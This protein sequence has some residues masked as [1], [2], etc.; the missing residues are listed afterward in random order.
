[1]TEDLDHDIADCGLRAGDHVITP[2]GLG[3]VC[4]CEG[5]DGNKTLFDSS[6]PLIVK[7]MV[8]VELDGIDGYP[9]RWYH[10]DDVEIITHG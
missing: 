2:D 1:M 10:P 9:I 4:S 7:G 5:Y 6:Q 3:T 8:E